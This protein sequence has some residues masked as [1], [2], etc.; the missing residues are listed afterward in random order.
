MATARITQNSLIMQNLMEFYDKDNNLEV[1]LSIINGDS[2]ISLRIVDWF[3]TNY[4]KQYYV[5]YATPT[6][7]RFKVYVDYKLK[8]RSYSK[9][10]FDPFCRWERIS[11]PY[12]DG[13][14]IQTTFYHFFPFHR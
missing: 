9:R 1:M 11:I 6:E 12:N 5:T 8:L 2:S 7:P 14:Y 10:R 3:A 4:A 13:E